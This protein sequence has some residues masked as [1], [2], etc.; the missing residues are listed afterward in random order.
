MDE[1]A[2]FVIRHSIS[3]W[4]YWSRNMPHKLLLIQNPMYDR[5]R[6]NKE[7][8]KSPSSHPAWWVAPEH[9]TPQSRDTR[10]DI[11]NQPESR[12]HQ[13]F[14]KFPIF[15]IWTDIRNPAA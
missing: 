9:H 12:R 8:E 6:T 1:S 13:P 5:S 2:D 14:G 4:R 10:S 11:A 3:P 15:G 7:L